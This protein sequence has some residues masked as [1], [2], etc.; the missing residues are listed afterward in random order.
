MSDLPD[1]N[2]FL[3]LIRLD[4]E[5]KYPLRSS[6]D[7]KGLPRMEAHSKH[8]M[9]AGL[10]DPS[11][12]KTRTPL[13]PIAFEDGKRKD[14]Y[15]DIL[16]HL[17]GLIQS[18]YEPPDG[19]IFDPSRLGQRQQKEM[20]REIVSIGHSIYDLIP[21][22]G[23]L[24]GWFNDLLQASDSSKRW[25]EEQHVT[26][27]TN[28]FNI[29]WYWMRATD[30]GP[31]LCEACSLGMLQLTNR[32]I[33]E[34]DGDQDESTEAVTEPL[35]ALLINGPGQSNLPF[36]GEEL[37]ILK[38]VIGQ[39]SDPSRPLNRA[40]RRQ[41]TFE[42][43]CIESLE[44]FQ[45]LKSDV[46]PRKQRSMYRLVHYT[47][48]WS[49]DNEEEKELMVGA[50]RLDAED[51][52]HFV[53]SAVLALDGCSSS[54]GLQAWSEVENLTGKLLN[55]GALGCI[56][57]TLPVKNDPIVC[58]AFWE[59]LYG[60]LLRGSTLGL[61]LVKGRQALK[62]HFKDVRSQNPSWAFYQLIGNPSVRLGD[63]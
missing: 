43:V 61:A 60:A 23:P 10:L 24:F 36:M 35:R 1:K 59:A 5:E 63:A 41:R 33:A 37:A 31:S 57:T 14:S 32:N 29:P 58:R 6:L 12:T 40:L 34:I 4:L 18:F 17:E 49:L 52:K 7:S 51:L 26:I 25:P 13:T 54:S 9:I 47:G 19:Y 48:H 53:D 27:I 22:N 20:G 3:F 16:D 28:D 11:Q 46:H 44:A 38:D 55:L 50:K 2:V 45:K 39:G 8:A 15:N 30:W 56:V 62:A 21:K 42:P